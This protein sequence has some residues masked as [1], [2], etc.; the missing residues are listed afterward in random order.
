MITILE[1]VLSKE[2]LAEI[3]TT[4]NRGQF[5]AGAETAGWAAQSV[6]KK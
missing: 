3:N 5:H 6:K 4:L 1:N 2:E